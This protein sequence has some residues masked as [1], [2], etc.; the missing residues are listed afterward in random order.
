MVAGRV[1]GAAGY[2]TPEK[3]VMFG[4]MELEVPLTLV[5][6]SAYTQ[7]QCKSEAAAKITFSLFCRRYL[8]TCHHPDSHY[9]LCL[10]TGGFVQNVP[11]ENSR[12]LVCFLCRGRGEINVL[13]IIKRPLLDYLNH[14]CRGSL[15][16]KP[17]VF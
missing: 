1:T 11:E 14:R 4:E 15:V 16:G 10:L 12:Y 7:R 2:P 13:F 9:P 6:A 3:W 8:A 5:C 17:S